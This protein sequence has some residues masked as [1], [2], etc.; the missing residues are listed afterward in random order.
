MSGNIL[1]GW[2]EIFK[3]GEHTASSG[4]RRLWNESDLD[5]I[6]DN[7]DPKTIEAPLVI[8]HPK[9]DD[10]AYGWVEALKRVGPV[11]MA[12]FK[13]VDPEFAEKVKS[14]RYKKRSISLLP[15]NRLRHVGFLGGAL[16]AVE[17]LA[18]FSSTEFEIELIADEN[19]ELS[20]SDMQ[21][22]F[23]YC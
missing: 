6:V 20:F 16:P 12:K 11:L 22:M 8:G 7:Y 5:A 18:D 19:E 2:I 14:G 23:D 10:P 13:Q 9:T 17:G 21:A 15:G 1:N 4:N 3:I